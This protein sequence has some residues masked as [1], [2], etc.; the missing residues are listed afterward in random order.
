MNP[1][2][3]TPVSASDRDPERKEV[4]GLPDGLVWVRIGDL[5]P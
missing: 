2:R 1:P 4:G 3:L 5:Y